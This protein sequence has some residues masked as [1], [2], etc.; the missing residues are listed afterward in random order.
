MAHA[1][2]GQRAVIL[3]AI[4][5]AGNAGVTDAELETRLGM[6]AQSIS[7]RRGELV[8]LG[9][10]EPVGRRRPTPRGRSAAVWCATTAG[11]REGDGLAG[12]VA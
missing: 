12:G 2:V 7:P 9:L 4:I 3:R 8:K 5:E 11:M 10:I 1:A 6:R